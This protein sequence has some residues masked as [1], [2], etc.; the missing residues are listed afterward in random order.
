MI[1]WLLIKL[2]KKNLLL[3][4]WRNTLKHVLSIDLENSDPASAVTYTDAAI[5]MTAGSDEWDR[6]NIFR[7][8]RPCLF[9]DGEVIGYLDPN[10][11]T[12]YT[13]G[14]DADI[15][16]GDAGDVM[17]EIPKLGV[18][19]ATSGSTLTVQV[20]DDP[21]AEGFQYYAHTRETSGDRE[22]VYIGA[23]LGYELSSKLRSLSG[24]QPTASI[25]IGQARTF[26]QTNGDGYD[27]IAFYQLTL[28]Q[29]LFLIRYKSRDTQTA[30]GLGYV[31]GSGSVPCATGGS[32]NKGMNF[33]EKTGKYQIKFLGIED[34]WGN[35]YYWLDGLISTYS[36]HA[37]T[38]TDNFNDSGLDYVDRGQLATSDVNGYM[39][40]PQG[41]SEL[42]FVFRESGASSTTYFSDFASFSKNGVTMFGG[43]WNRD[44]NTGAFSVV[45]SASKSASHI[46]ARLMYL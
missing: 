1:K 37:L 11:F 27:Q 3:K 35:L 33:G 5:G 46:G 17:I 18:K 30:L 42:G 22:K 43:Q 14:T 41:T 15:S 45:I 10:N 34:F 16:S 9:K 31:K 8:I 12:K 44:L 26:A 13:D 38:A 6:A 32:F 39:K 24:K 4:H 29:C 36:Y 21:N 7:G 19:I 23:F 40:T 25:T 28:L 20:T 2:T